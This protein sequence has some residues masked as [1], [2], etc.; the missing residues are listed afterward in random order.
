M[1]DKIAKL[2]KEIRNKISRINHGGCIHF[3]YYFSK[4]LR[5]LGI[6]HKVVFNNH[7]PIDLRYD[8]FDPCYH[9]CVYVDGIGYIDGLETGSIPWGPT[10]YIRRANVSLKKLDYFRKELEWNDLYDTRQNKTVEKLI[11][12]FIY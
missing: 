2:Q 5:E 7:S 10:D 1:K 8:W 3:A 4:R 9:V 12:K 6:E 11:K